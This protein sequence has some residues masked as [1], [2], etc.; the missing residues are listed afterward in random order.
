MLK[1][2][3]APQL[4]SN[5]WCHLKKAFNSVFILQWLMKC[6]VLNMVLCMCSH[7]LGVA[8]TP[9]KFSRDWE[10]C[11]SSK[12]FVLFCTF[13]TLL[14]PFLIFFQWQGKYWAILNTTG[15]L[16]TRLKP[17]VTAPDEHLHSLAARQDA[18]FLLG[19]HSCIWS[20]Y[21]LWR[22]GPV[23]AVFSPFLLKMYTL[24]FSESAHG[25]FSL[26]FSWLP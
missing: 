13:F 4:L 9:W 3:S 1:I 26:P 20:F 15:P 7:W 21:W 14:S 11:S 25:L 19:S 8:L 10:C 18:F 24:L 2:V 17:S 22:K 6:T 5:I 16:L 23:W 12:F